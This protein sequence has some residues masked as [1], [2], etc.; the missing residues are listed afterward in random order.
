VPGAPTV[1]LCHL[2]RPKRTLFQLF[3][4]GQRSFGLYIQPTPRPSNAG[5]TL[6][7]THL[8]LLE[9]RNRCVT[10]KPVEGK[11]VSTFSLRPA[12]GAALVALASTLM[13]NAASAGAVITYGNTS[14]GVN[15]TGELNFSGNGPGGPLTYGVYRAGVG[16]AISPGCPCEG[17]GVALNDGLSTFATWANQSTGSGGFG[18]GNL[19]GSTS[20]TATSSV[21]MADLNVNIRHAYG[22]SLV[23]DVFQAQVTITNNTS[24][25]L[26]DLVYRRAMD[27]D[28]P[29]TTFNEYVSHTGV[30]ANLVSNGGNVLYASDNG[31]ATSNP[32]IGASYISADTVNTDFNKNGP[33][34]HGSV[35]DFSFGN[36]A[37]GASRI[38][39]IFYGSA[40]NEASALSKATA[41]GADLYSLGQS[42][43]TPTASPTFL[44]AFGGVG[45]LEPGLTEGAPIL[46][47]VPAPGTFTFDAPVARRWYDPPFAEGFDISIV[48]GTFI[49]IEAPTGFSD[50]EILATDGTMLDADFDAGEIY[51]FASGVHGAFKIRGTHLDVGAPG[52]ASAFPLFVDFTPGTTSMTWTAAL[53]AATPVPEPETYAML[54]VG[55]AV[56]AS[57]TR[58]ARRTS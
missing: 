1:L 39:N 27:W 2:K 13:S 40:D 28:V 32:T 52:F 30:T 7:S 12:I 31:F 14:L 53:E 21:N 33:A 41:L 34:D 29:P 3:A 58:R 55:L 56:V 18:S 45:G 11:I 24:S 50:L 49:S 47:F 4:S 36:L 51:T 37:P 57:T 17:W 35:F 6:R 23:A 43:D 15:D 26:N 16:D 8:R 9:H 42:S 38:F 46:P 22:P 19:F 48:G 5:S 54:L 20:T 10:Q 25:T 44:F